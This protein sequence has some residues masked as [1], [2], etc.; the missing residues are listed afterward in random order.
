MKKRKKNSTS[1]TNMGK[2]TEAISCKW[3]KITQTSFNTTKERVHLRCGRYHQS[4]FPAVPEYGVKRW[5][6]CGYLE[7]PNIDNY[8][9]LT[10]SQILEGCVA[11]L[12]KP[13]PRKKKSSYGSLAPIPAP[14]RGPGMYEAKMT[15]EHMIVCLSTD[16]RKNKNFWSDGPRDVPK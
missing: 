15:E 11:F 6:V 16:V 10:E 8:K 5:V 9:H 12:N 13:L 4:V 2:E 1:G 14:S 7:I 3:K